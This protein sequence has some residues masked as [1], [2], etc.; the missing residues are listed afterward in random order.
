MASRLLDLLL[1]RDD[2]GSVRVRLRGELDLSGAG[3]LEE[4]LDRLAADGRPVVLD[5]RELTFMDSTGLRVLLQAA[6]R[7]RD[8][9][10]DLRMLAPAGGEALMTIEE[11]GAAALLPIERMPGEGSET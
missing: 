4:S 11:T 2:Q 5:L 10:W 7:A 1:E 6:E 9:S 3:R 8:D